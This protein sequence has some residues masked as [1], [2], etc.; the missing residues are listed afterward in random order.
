MSHF[1]DAMHNWIIRSGGFENASV[2]KALHKTKFS[3]FESYLCLSLRNQ[4]NKA[5][6]TSS[7][8]SQSGENTSKFVFCSHS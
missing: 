6:E 2:A 3:N 4:F 8:F 7:L 5:R 1:G